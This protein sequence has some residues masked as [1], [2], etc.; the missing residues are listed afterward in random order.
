[1]PIPKDE[2]H[3]IEEGE[4]LPDLRPDTTQG[5]IYHFLLTNAD[6]AFRQSEILEHTDVP[7]GSVGPTLSR[8]EARGLLEHRGQFWSIADAEH[9]IAS[10]GRLSSATAE[11]IDEGFS[12]AEVEAWMETA[13]EPVDRPSAESEGE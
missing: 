7:K 3:S 12:D 1:M 4:T 13:V 2:F 11:E 5:E 6:K 8:L 9:A 10:A